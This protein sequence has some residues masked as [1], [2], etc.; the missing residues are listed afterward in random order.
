MIEAQ[1]SVHIGFLLF[2]PLPFVKCCQVLISDTSHKRWTFREA[3]TTPVFSFQFLFPTIDSML[4]LFSNICFLQFALKQIV[5]VSTYLDPPNFL[6]WEH[7]KSWKLAFGCL[8]DIFSLRDRT[9]WKCGFRMFSW[10]W[11]KPN[12]HRYVTY[13]YIYKH[14]QHRLLGA[15]ASLFGLF[16]Q[17]K[18]I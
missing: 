10:C 17:Y 4:P 9:Y 7:A 14:I 11:W 6:A 16:V 13:I 5:P 18:A 12:I 15:G 8:W 3:I 1:L 2:Q